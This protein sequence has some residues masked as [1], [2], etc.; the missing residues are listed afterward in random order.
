MNELSGS[1]GDIFWDL[2]SWI[3]YVAGSEL[4][5]TIF[6]ANP[7]DEE[8]EY[9]L[10]AR[11][12]TD[13]EVISEES[14]KVFG[15]AWFKVDPGDWLRLHG[16]LRFEESNLTL[17]L[18]LYEKES[19][20][21]VDAVSAFLVEPSAAAWPPGWPGA[22]GVPGTPEELTDWGWMM[23]LP[24]MMLMIG[25]V[26]PRKAEETGETEERKLLP[27]GRSE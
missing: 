12:S 15:Y 23:I 19:G 14:I 13:A 27:V 22:P 7:T 21:A 24:M 11:L 20:E 8:K 6:V 26:M 10:M 17:S 5:T 25:M 9:A 1:L 3:T 2:P 4:G 18:L 16:G